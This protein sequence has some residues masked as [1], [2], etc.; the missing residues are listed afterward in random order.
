METDINTAFI[1]SIL[2]INKTKIYPNGMY[3]SA[4]HLHWEQLVTHHWLQLPPK[5]VSNNDNTTKQVRIHKYRNVDS[6]EL[7]HLHQS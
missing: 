5:S 6:F 7:C 4:V 3:L 1:K 2:Q